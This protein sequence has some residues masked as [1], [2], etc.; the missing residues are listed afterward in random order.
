MIKSLSYEL[1]WTFKMVKISLWV[2]PG[3]QTVTDHSTLP[4]ITD[5]L[6]LSSVWT[7]GS[8]KTDDDK[9]PG[10]WLQ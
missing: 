8:L 2:L 10:G 7:T 1:N 6:E 5:H 9:P 4:I 3:G